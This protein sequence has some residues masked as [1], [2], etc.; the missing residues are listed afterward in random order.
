MGN[1]SN[2]KLSREF[3]GRPT[4]HTPSATAG[5]AVCYGVDPGTLCIDQLG[6]AS[7]CRVIGQAGPA[8]AV[9]VH[10]VDLP[11]SVSLR[12]ECD[13]QGS[14]GWRGRGRGR[15]RRA[16]V[17][18]GIRRALDKPAWESVLL[19]GYRSGGFG[20]SRQ[21]SSRRPGIGFRLGSEDKRDAASVRRPTWE[22]VFRRVTGQ[23][24]LTRAVRV[25]H[26]DL[27]VPATLRGERDAASV[28]RPTWG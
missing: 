13:L 2:W 18:R 10:H 14:P 6:K 3:G 27:F 26:L 19:P 7:S 28:R 5:V 22:S 1:S 15:W 8:R 4:R 23:A 21:R 9:S 16:S 25:H 24:R 17:G 12:V 20:P 11:V